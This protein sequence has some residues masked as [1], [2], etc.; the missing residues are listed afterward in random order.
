MNNLR[1]RIKARLKRALFGSKPASPEMKH[2]PKPP[3]PPPWMAQDV[4]HEHH[5]HSHSHGHAHDHDHEPQVEA[6]EPTLEKI[7]AE[8]TANPSTYKFILTDRKL[9]AFSASAQDSTFKEHQLMP[10][11][12]IDGITSFF[13]ANNYVVTTKSADKNWEDLVS[14]ILEILK[15]L[16]TNKPAS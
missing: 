3:P 9:E 14:S 7:S 10:L 6:A 16:P 11:L 1:K 8:K 13:C 12:Q 4:E 15:T 5:N 2:R